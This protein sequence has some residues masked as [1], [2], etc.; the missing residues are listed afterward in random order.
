MKLKTC[1]I[2]SLALLAIGCTSKPQ[3]T[4]NAASSATVAAT[5]NTNA[6]SIPSSIA[7]PTAPS[8]SNVSANAEDASTSAKDVSK[9]PTIADNK[10]KAKEEDDYRNADALQKIKAGHTPQPGDRAYQDDSGSTRMRYISHRPV[11]ADGNPYES[12]GFSR[13]SDDLNVCKQLAQ[14]QAQG[15]TKKT[16]SGIIYAIEKA[17]K[18]ELCKGETGEGVYVT[19]CEMCADGSS[20]DDR[21]PDVFELDKHFSV[22]FRGGDTVDCYH[23]I[24]K[25]M[26]VGETRVCEV[27]A[28]LCQIPYEHHVRSNDKM[29]CRVTLTGLG[30]EDLHAPEDPS[31]MENPEANKGPEPEGGYE[32]QRQD[33][34]AAE[35]PAAQA[36]AT[37]KKRPAAEAPATAKQPA[38][39]AAATAKQPAAKA[40]AAAKQ[41]A[42]KASAASK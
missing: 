5:E 32:P 35:Q 39:K 22:D 17:G 20:L 33:P 34:A 1:A 21:S 3:E 12:E 18:G 16:D 28:Q 6:P 13:V 8:T 4:P 38:A 29:Y 10:V 31:T 7:A 15:K 2:L 9:L 25:G 19:V 23:D 26:K 27:P 14:F 24:V 36:P 42:A 41:P 30:V 40:P 11:D 37:G